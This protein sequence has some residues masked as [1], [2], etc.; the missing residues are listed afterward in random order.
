MV[1]IEE[2]LGVASPAKYYAPVHAA[3]DIDL[4]ALEKRAIELLKKIAPVK[5][6]TSIDKIHFLPVFPK[7]DLGFDSEDWAKDLS[8]GT[9][10]A[11][12][13]VITNKTISKMC[14]AIWGVELLN[15][16]ADNVAYIHFMKGPNT[17]LKIPL[18]P[19]IIEGRKIVPFPVVLIYADEDVMNVKYY[20]VATGT[21]KIRWLCIKAVREEDSE[22]KSR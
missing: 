4:K 22:I 11:E 12:N 6:K 21:P 10:N 9:A 16:D 8:A 13:D 17:I 18:V 3:D 7:T 1:Y 15:A 14:I 2:V 5:L 19:A 20:I